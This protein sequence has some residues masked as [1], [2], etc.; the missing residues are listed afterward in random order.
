MNQ[1]FKLIRYLCGGIQSKAAYYST[2]K[3]IET[4]GTRYVDNESV[5]PIKED[6][7]SWS[8]ANKLDK[9]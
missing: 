6:N 3:P 7:R 9:N 1:M 5:I 8:Q 2:L 4:D